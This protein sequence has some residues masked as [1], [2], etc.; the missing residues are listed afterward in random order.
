MFDDSRSFI[1]RP[2]LQ[3]TLDYEFKDYLEAGKDEEV[4]ARLKKWHGRAKLSETQAESA[5]IQTFFVETWGYGLSG[6][7]SSDDHTLVPKF[8]VPGAGAKGGSGKADVAL[9]WFLGKANEVPQVLC[10]FKDIKSDLDTKQNR[11]GSNHT[12]VEQCLN[13]VKG[14]RRNLFGNETVQPWWGLVTDMNEFRLYWWD[15]APQNYIKFTI[16]SKKDLFARHDLLAAGP[17]AQFDRFLFWKLFQRDQLISLSG[18]PALWRTVEKQW[19][20]E[21]EIEEEF[22][23]HYKGVRERLFSVLRT[24]NNEFKGSATDLL[25]VSQKLLD[26]FIFAFY[27]EDMGERMLFPPQFIRDH[28]KH[29]S[30]E[31][32]YD[33]EGTEIWEFFRKFFKLM[34][35][36]GK[37]GQQ[38]V[39][40][41][42]GGLF[43]DDALIESLTIPNHVFAA[44]NQ[45][46]NDASLESDQNTLLYLSARYNYAAKGDAKESLTLYT[47]G[48]IFEQSITELE[49]RIGELEQRD[50]VAKL[51]K[52]KRDGVYYTPEWVV[53]YLV[54]ETMGPWFEK[55]QEDCGL[56]ENAKPSAAQLNAYLTRLRDMR[57]VDPACGSGAFLIS[58]FRKLLDERLA[59]AKRMQTLAMKDASG[60]GF[61]EAELVSDILKNNIYGV[62]INPSS[63]EIAKLAL[64]LHSARAK[65]P[66]SSLD[67]NIRCGNSLVAHDCWA[68]IKK[69]PENEARVNPFDWDQVFPFK[70]DIVLGNPP[71]V[72]LQN[73][74]KVDPDVVGYLRAQREVGTYESAQTGNFDLYLPFIEK[75]LRLLS[76]GG[77]MAYIAPSLWTVNEYGEG[78]RKLIHRTKQLE[79]WIDFKSFQV[80]K[81]A[82][83]YTALQFFTEVENL[84]VRITGSPEGELGDLDWKDTK[85]RVGASEFEP[86]SEWLMLTGTERKLISRLNQDC[87]RLD[88]GSLTEGIT[89]GLQTSADSIYHLIRLGKDAY[90][91]SA[92]GVDPFEVTIEDDIMRP[93]IS[94]P[95]AK[96]Y[97]SP[98][99]DTYLL[100][101]YEPADNGQIGLIS[102][103][104]LQRKF[105]SALRYLKAFEKELRARENNQFNDQ[106]WYRFGR[107]QNLDKQETE[108]LIVAQLVP[109]MRVSADFDANKYLNNVRVNG[110][111]PAKGCDLA[112]LLGV[113][114]GNVADFVFR[115]IGKPKDGGWFEAN[116]QFIA[117]LPIP[118][119]NKKQQTDIGKRARDLQKAWT[120][121]R[122][123]VD[124]ANAR[125]STIGRAT[126][127]ARFLWPDLPDIETLKLQAPK[128]MTLTTEK[129]KWAKDKFDALE[130]GSIETLQGFLDAGLPLTVDFT[131]GEL[132][133]TSEGRAVFNKIYLDTKDGKLAEVY[134]RFLILGM[135]RDTKSFARD[136]ARIPSGAD[137]PAAKQFMQRVAALIEQTEQIRDME[138]EMNE[139]LYELYK[140]SADERTLIEKDCAKRRLL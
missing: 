136:L 99:T 51:S 89:V 73:L 43:A 8:D 22:Y 108:K 54:D 94:G 83:T 41:I 104:N 44:L 76:P 72:K 115:R 40:H 1:G 102:E 29:R 59:L 45:G 122:D 103:V 81:E 120:K 23:N 67:D 69:T 126:Y 31:G 34:N 18:K 38:P 25:R 92:Q 124:E 97:E 5:F 20:R 113:L 121:R 86:S 33:T 61:G 125:L 110:I 4:L 32:Y 78:L 17:D 93:L 138:T 91:C 100:F 71:Y 98:E 87:L 88:D 137:T 10:E 90:K 95:E 127:K 26:R 80:F 56:K 64:W 109:S 116:K 49:Y 47:L 7:G 129:N 140:L 24:H 123:L 63:V 9:G 85:F 2:F 55:A 101:P 27:C 58:A 106:R 70:F 53:N 130:E 111:L 105:P 16:S 74:M 128:A 35:T 65:S 3:S 68:M 112:F 117:P 36:G 96:R 75:G 42:N 28:I 39:P 118:H 48:R 50:T 46:A 60:I 133:M 19:L 84:H 82:I 6:Q 21:R 57:V 13:Y 11:K 131:K 66:L 37:I 107:N 134:W 135:P 139:K 119:A 114:N 30:I 12:P 79:R 52:R 132:S 14:S 62:D 15:R 77:R